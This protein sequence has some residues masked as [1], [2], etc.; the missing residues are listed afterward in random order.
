MSRRKIVTDPAERARILERLKRDHLNRQ[1]GYREQA[2]KLLPHVCGK[3]ARDFSGP[4]LRELTVHHKDCNH[5]NNPADGSNWE[6]LCVSC[7]EHEHS[8]SL[9]FQRHGSPPAGEPRDSTSLQTPFAGLKDLLK[10]RK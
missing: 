10:G 2:L 6:L 9:E 5:E 7:H 3:C 4:R 8:G 1:S